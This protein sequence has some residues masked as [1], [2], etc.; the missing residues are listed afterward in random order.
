MTLE[1]FRLDVKLTLITGGT[2][3]IDL[4][5]AQAFGE[6]GARLVII[7]SSPVPEAKRSLR[8]TVYEVDFIKADLEPGTSAPATG[9]RGTQAPRAHRRAGQ[10]RR[11]GDSPRQRR[12]RR[13]TLAPHHEPE[14]RRG[15][16]TPSKFV[17]GRTTQ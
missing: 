5:I 8:D 15:V 16:A 2:R 14:P 11:R 12:L 1:K 4:A 9:R 3:G 13:S 7:S 6:A 17:L 10:Q